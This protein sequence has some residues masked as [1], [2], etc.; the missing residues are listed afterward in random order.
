LLHVKNTF[1]QKSIALSFKCTY[2]GT[3]IVQVVFDFVPVN[4]LKVDQI[5]N[6]TNTQPVAMIHD[7]IAHAWY[8]AINN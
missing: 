4:S 5:A 1:T 3:A 2:H 8:R 7:A 6:G